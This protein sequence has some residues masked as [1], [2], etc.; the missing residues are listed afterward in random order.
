[1]TPSE[2]FKDQPSVDKFC[3]L[4][5]MSY[6]QVESIA[7]GVTTTP[8]FSDLEI[9]PDGTRTFP[10]FS[11]YTWHLIDGT[12]PSSIDDKCNHYTVG[13][14]WQNNSCAADVVIFVA[15]QFNIGISHIEQMGEVGVHALSIP[16]LTIRDIVARA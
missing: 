16:A 14:K 3:L 15:I 11:M 5:G 12:V 8:N 4:A 13:P 10:P 1:M 6:N 9:H 7:L 2:V